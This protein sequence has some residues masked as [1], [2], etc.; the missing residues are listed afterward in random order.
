MK[1]YMQ[2]VAAFAVGTIITIFIAIAVWPK[3]PAPPTT[4]TYSSMKIDG[5]TL[6]GLYNGNFSKL[7]F[8]AAFNPANQRFFLSAG[9]LDS[10]DREVAAP[11]GLLSVLPGFNT[12]TGERLFAPYYLEHF[13]VNGHV[14]LQ[15]LV[16]LMAANPGGYLILDAAD[17][18]DIDANFTK[19][20]YY[21]ISAFK[22]DRTRIGT[23]VLLRIMQLNPS[24]PGRLY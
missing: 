17:Y 14:Q 7:N 2:S 4:L 13:R 10:L 1:P 6:V 18:K 16:A 24:P 12:F 15:Q 3:E 9:V 8:T 11:N 22:A 5:R 19:N 23:N 20:I 21:K